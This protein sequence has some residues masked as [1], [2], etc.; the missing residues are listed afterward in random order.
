ME[1][2]Q[3]DNELT[4]EEIPKNLAISVG[5]IAMACIIFGLI[6]GANISQLNNS[7]NSAQF[8]G[9]DKNFLMGLAYTTGHCE[10][11]GLQ[12]KVLPQTI[13]VQDKNIVIGLPVCVE[14]QDLNKVI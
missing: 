13:V 5:L 10:R 2:K 12:S 1:E 11:L 3:L 4:K 8:S 14:R 9:Q 6:I 7:L